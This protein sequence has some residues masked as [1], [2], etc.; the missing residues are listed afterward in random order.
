LKKLTLQK[1]DDS[2]LQEHICLSS[3]DKC[4]FFGEYTGRQGYSHSEMNQLI[5]NFKKPM[6]KKGKADWHYKEKE[7]V[8]I[9]EL[10]LSIKAWPKL[11]EYTWVPM[12]PSRVKVDPVYDDRLLRVLLKI[13]ETEKN[14]D[15]RELLI[16]K[17]SRDLAHDPKSQKGL[18]F[19]TTSKILHWMNH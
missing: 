12:P 10:L 1:I 7:I 11:R 13:K 16:A 2:L 17:F 15:V 8:K 19:L 9:A 3:D 5:F 18:K 4:Y 14:L 6:E